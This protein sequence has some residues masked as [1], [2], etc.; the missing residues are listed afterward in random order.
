MVAKALNFN[1]FIESISKKNPLQD[2]AIKSFLNKQDKIYWDRA[3]D[4]AEK[5]LSFIEKQN[6]P[7]RYIV[8]AYLKMCRDMMIEQVKF[9]KHGKYTCHDSA[10]ANK[11]VYS[12]ESE[13]KSYMY[14]LALSQFLWP[15]HYMMYDFY[16]M[17]SK[18]LTDVRSYLEIG[19]GHGLFLVEAI[20]LFH[21][22]Y[23]LAIDI[24]PISKRISEEIVRHFTEN[25]QC[26]F[27]VQD[28]NQMETEK[29]DYIVMNEVLE[30][31]D[32]PESV[33]RKI[34]GMLDSKGRFFITTCANCPAIDHVYLYDS[35]A[36]IRK[37][38][39]ES[40][41][42]IVSDLPLAVGDFDESEWD[43]GKVEVNYAAMLKKV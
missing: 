16:V 5:F 6:I 39:Q 31:L 11:N 13:M 40:G 17:E 38:I 18:K 22:A 7:I 29:F 33:L 37:Q 34:H 24:S 14:G 15:N 1:K 21:G 8:N 25:S 12:S 20:R 9:K 3:E 32:N 23:F 36:H 2:K 35:V 30:H 41:F 26:E 43:E 10:Q 19:P 42:N 28:V 27:R 4:F